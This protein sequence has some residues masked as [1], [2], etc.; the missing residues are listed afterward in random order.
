MIRTNRRYAV[1][2]LGMSVVLGACVGDPKDEETVEQVS[3]A[4]S[5]VGFVTNYGAPAAVAAATQ[6]LMSVWRGCQTGATGQK[7][8][9]ATGQNEEIVGEAF[10]QSGVPFG[11]PPDVGQSRIYTAGDRLKSSPAVSNHTDLGWYLVVWQQDWTTTD[12][13]IKG[14]VVTDDG[15]PV[16]EEFWINSDLDNEKA[17][18]VT[19]IRDAGKWLVTYRRTHGSTT[20]ITG[21]L[22]DTAGNIFDS[23]GNPGLFEDL[24]AS[25]VSTSATKHTT[26][27]SSVTGG[28][29]LTWND[30]KFAF[31][32]FESFPIGPTSTISGA[33]G[34]VG[35]FNEVQ[36]QFAVAWREGSGTGTKVRTRTLPPGCT[37]TSC[38]TA[39]VTVITP[40]SGAN[41][42]NLPL[43]AANGR[44]FG[45][46]A[47]TLPATT[48]HIVLTTVDSNGLLGLSNGSLTPTCGGSLQGG[49]SLG[50]IGT[51]AVATPKN[52]A[53]AREFLVYNAFC[54][55]SPNTNK[56]Q[57]A[58]APTNVFDTANFKVS[59]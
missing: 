2:A 9:C 46:M 59:D 53:L 20:A 51:V 7:G 4:L 18:T 48:K 6:S 28:V 19:F 23:H 38:A 52:D 11:T 16:T 50:L 31:S 39:A 3:S 25:G 14:R 37:T 12:S 15:R 42:L 29:L 26:S 54:G 5:D 32:D 22:V 30:N 55:T 33:T 1:V 45:I 8:S 57:M 58:S 43:I 40:P 24:V 44:G 49:G 56:I 13:D 41:G 27:F 35:A 21:S 17:P 10:S 36:S 47:G 34:I